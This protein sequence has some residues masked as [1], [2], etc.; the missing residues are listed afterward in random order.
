[1]NRAGPDDFFNV[2][3]GIQNHYESLG[4]TELLSL[5]RMSHHDP[6]I[7]HDCLPALAAAASSLSPAQRRMLVESIART[8]ENHYPIG[9]DR[10]LAFEIACLLHDVEAFPEALSYL[11]ASAALHGDHPATR[12]NMGL[13]LARLGDVDGAA[14]CFARAMTLHPGFVPAG[15]LQSKAWSLSSP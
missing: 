13:C 9:E 10:D 12:W 11:R 8:W 3:R 2:R 6:R 5:L 1:M 7:L 4:F 15:A 14:S